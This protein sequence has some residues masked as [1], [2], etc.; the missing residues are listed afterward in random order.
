MKR[1]LTQ[2]RD[3]LLFSVVDEEGTKIL[4]EFLKHVSSKCAK[5]LNRDTDE[6]KL[7]LNI[8]DSRNFYKTLQ[9]L[10][11][12]PE[13]GLDFQSSSMGMGVQAAL[14]IA[15][16]KAYS[17]LK[18]ANNT[19]IFIDEPE[20]FLHPQA[21]RNFYN[22]LNELADS[23]TQIFH[24]THSPA[25]INLANFDQ[26]YLVRKNKDDGTHL[27]TANPTDFVKD[28]KIRLGIDRHISELMKIYAYAYD[29]T[30][31]TQKANEAFFSKKK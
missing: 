30:G 5:Q 18:L 13:C 28:F 3:E 24:T 19:P 31:D 4:P 17:K 22:I 10:V 16:L 15:I 6:F 26:I 25:F 8:Y 1:D 29:N 9:I 7:D 27:R 2:I 14:S 21:Q 12:D 20:L 23:G 11:T